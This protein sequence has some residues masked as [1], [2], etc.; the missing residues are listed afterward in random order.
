MHILQGKRWIQAEQIIHPEIRP[1]GPGR[2]QGGKKGTTSGNP[3]KNRSGRRFCGNLGMLGTSENCYQIGNKWVTNI[4]VF[5]KTIGEARQTKKKQQHDSGLVRWEPLRKP[6]VYKMLDLEVDIQGGIREYYERVQ[7]KHDRMVAQTHLREILDLNRGNLHSCWNQPG[8]SCRRDK[9]PRTSG[10][11]A[12]S[13][14]RG[15]RPDDEPNC[16]PEFLGRDDRTHS[17]TPIHEYYDM[18]MENLN[19]FPQ[20]DP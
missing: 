18:S 4:W 9:K 8:R 13:A 17:A 3:S 10:R 5:F 20:N 19:L 11:P 6:E 15:L 14:K 12:Q 16:P 1:V 2:G 7:R